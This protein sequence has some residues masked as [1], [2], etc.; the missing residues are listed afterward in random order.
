MVAPITSAEVTRAR[1]PP[2]PGSPWGGPAPDAEVMHE[3]GA[4]ERDVK[5]TLSL[6][7]G[8]H[9]QQRLERYR[10]GQYVVY[11]MNASYCMKCIFLAVLFRV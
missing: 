5:L 3:L 10:H 1:V 7:A 6:G 11:L 2:G 8:K 4:V 9:G